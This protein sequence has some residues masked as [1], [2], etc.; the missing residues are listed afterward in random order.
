[1]KP[2]RVALDTHDEHEELGRACRVEA[3]HEVD[4]D[5]ARAEG[6][7]HA[8]GDGVALEAQLVTM[9]APEADAAHAAVVCH[10]HDQL[11]ALGVGEGVQVPLEPGRPRRQ[12]RLELVAAVLVALDLLADMVGEARGRPAR[13]GAQVGQ[14]Q[15]RRASAAQ[16]GQRHLLRVR[17]FALFALV[18][19]AVA[20]AL[21]AV[22]PCRLVRLVCEEDARLLCHALERAMPRL[23]AC[24]ARQRRVARGMP[25]AQAAAAAI[26]PV[27]RRWEVDAAKMCDLICPPPRPLAGAWAA[28]VRTPPRVRLGVDED[29]VV[30]GA[31]LLQQRV[32][33]APMCVQEDEL[34]QA[35]PK[36]LLHVHH[37]GRVH[38]ASE[39][40]RVLMSVSPLR[41][42]RRGAKPARNSF[43][44]FN[45]IGPFMSRAVARCPSP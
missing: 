31:E 43:L 7:L 6:R 44:P 33:R 8:F 5:A 38:D 3:W 15:L 23:A 28:L 17:I 24:K 36:L 27:V 9:R 2:H 14:R 35:H 42:A 40:P 21:A 19:T 16:V 11:A 13:R 22:L 4:L 37:L 12:R 39:V 18:A 10:A 25:G 1:M 45:F 20:A 41:S 32:T 34:V 26:P 30:D 29:F